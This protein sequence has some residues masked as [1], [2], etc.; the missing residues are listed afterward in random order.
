MSDL[1]QTDLLRMAAAAD[2]AG[3][4]D[5]PRVSATLDNPLC[6]DRVT[7]DIRLD[8][9][10]VAAL[11]HETKACV[12]CQAA[13]AVIARHAGGLTAE[14]LAAELGAVDALL[15]GEAAGA[16]H[17]AEL[18]VFRPVARVKSR[19]ACVRLPFRA[20]EAAFK[21]AKAS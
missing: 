21:A 19:H 1:Y 5:E 20:L 10:R 2:G 8:G 13:S 14:A 16:G 11:A 4:L 17:W 15:K 6:G 3:R 18:D 12:V 7:M 9:D